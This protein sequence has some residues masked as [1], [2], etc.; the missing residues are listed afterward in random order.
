MIWV[1]IWIVIATMLHRD[2]RFR[3]LSL[4]RRGQWLTA[5]RPA[6]Q[7]PYLRLFLPSCSHTMICPEP[8]VPPAASHVDTARLRRKLCYLGGRPT[9]FFDATQ[10]H[11]WLS[12]TNR[13]DKK[14]GP[15]VGAL[16]TRTGCKDSAGLRHKTRLFSVASIR[17]SKR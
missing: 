1:D 15:S 9:P 13:S 6:A 10:Q 2:N 4:E 8:A 11:R 7:D 5:Q 12:V 16:P 17:L 3:T 14:I